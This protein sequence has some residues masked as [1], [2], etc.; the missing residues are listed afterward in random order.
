[1]LIAE[2]AL[3][4]N[5]L[6]FHADALDDGLGRLCRLVEDLE[7]LFISGPR[8]PNSDPKQI[9]DRHSLAR[10]KDLGCSPSCTR[11]NNIDRR[12]LIQLLIRQK[13]QDLRTINNDQ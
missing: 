6:D 1:M 3:L 7:Q 8:A 5:F 13:L 11:D 4:L 12:E 10:Y 2:V 9:L